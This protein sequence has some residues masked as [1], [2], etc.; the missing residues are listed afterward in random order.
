MKKLYS[1]KMK[2]AFDKG[3][4]IFNIDTKINWREIL[5]NYGVNVPLEGGVC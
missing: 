5:D 4:D 3:K 2:K 1:K